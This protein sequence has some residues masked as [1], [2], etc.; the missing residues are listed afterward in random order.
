MIQTT[1]S[2]SAETVKGALEQLKE[3]MTAEEGEYAALVPA[4]GVA[5]I[6]AVEPEVAGNDVLV[7]LEPLLNDKVRLASL[8]G[9]IQSGSRQSQRANNIRQVILAVSYTHLT[10]P[11]KRI[12]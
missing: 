11:T 2:D 7:D 5:A 8:L 4:I 12:V 9:P 1:D 6:A 10:L 3:I